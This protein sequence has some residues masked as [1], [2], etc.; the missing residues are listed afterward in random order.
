ME[1]NWLSIVGLIGD[2]WDIYVNGS[3]YAL[4]IPSNCVTQL[5]LHS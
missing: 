4:I 1:K 3:T 2:S 5:V